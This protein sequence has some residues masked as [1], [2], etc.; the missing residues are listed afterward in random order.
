MF[1]INTHHIVR[2]ALSEGDIRTGFYSET[3]HSPQREGEGLN[4]A[5]ANMRRKTK[6]KGAVYRPVMNEMKKI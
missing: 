6:D 5:L 3:I 1:N 4:L 2:G